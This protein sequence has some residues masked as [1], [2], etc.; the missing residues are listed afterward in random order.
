M[1]ILGVGTGSADTLTIKALHILKSGKKVFL[2]TDRAPL[3]EY[4]REEGVEFE[5]LDG[6]YDSAEDF[7]ELADTAAKRVKEE[8]AILAVYGSLW[9][10]APAQACMK[11][12]GN[13]EV[14]PGVSFAEYALSKAGISDE[15][16][17]VFSAGGNLSLDTDHPIVITDV[18]DAD[19]ADEIIIKLLEEY[20][21]DFSA[22]VISSA[23][24]TDTT[25]HGLYKYS[26]WDFTC[27]IVLGKVELL[28]KERFSILD[29]EAVLDRLRA[30]GGCP[31]DR[32]QTH[33]SLMPYLLEESY[34]VLDA[35]QKKD[36]FSLADELGDVLLQVVFHSVIAK[37]HEEFVLSDVTTSICQKMIRRHT[38]IFGEDKCETSDDVRKNWEKQKR[39]QSGAKSVTETLKEVP[40]TMTAL[41]RA[42]KIQKKAASVGFDWDSAQGAIEKVLEE[43]QEVKA[44][45]EQGE[46]EARVYE[47]CGDLLFACVN[48][49]RHLGVSGEV[50]LLQACDKFVR[51][52]A[53]MESA[54]KE[55]GKELDDMTLEEM[56]AL[57]DEIKHK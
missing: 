29:L 7:D 16:A 9:Q 6:L 35:V 56:D 27:S 55:R 22:C 51:R 21:A 54:A 34:E 45:A 13:A 25:V 4:L 12:D 53:A 32:E 46:G 38:H 1:I 49:L 11:L 52:F 3:S 26:D 28:Q 50:A 18:G 23:G 10:N 14:I 40:A 24:R 15:G 19:L 8:D 43:T 17:R 20:P 5:S 37:A 41:M 31:W 2:Q 39:E 57:W 30:P 36:M 47:E 48:V 42:A 44:A 33:E